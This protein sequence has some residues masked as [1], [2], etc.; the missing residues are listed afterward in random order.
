[1]WSITHKHKHTVTLCMWMLT[2]LSLNKHAAHCEYTCANRGL[3][4]GVMVQSV[5]VSVRI[6]E[7]F[8]MAPFSLSFLCLLL[9]DFQLDYGGIVCLIFI[10]Y[11]CLSCEGGGL[12]VFLFIHAV[13]CVSKY[14]FTCSLL[15]PKRQRR[16]FKQFLCDYISLLASAPASAP[17]FLSGETAGSVLRR[18][19]RS[20]TGLFEELME[21]NLERECLEE[22]CDLEEAREVFEN[23]E[24]TVGIYLFSFYYIHIVCFFR[25]YWSETSLCILDGVLGGIYR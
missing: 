25:L 13:Q 12:S 5:C 10:D 3:Y 24:K 15:W 4:F 6:S 1:M 19:K 21:G 8:G 17:V 14:S 9:L 2:L 11:N 16:S 20:N 7:P 18:H 22:A 23:D